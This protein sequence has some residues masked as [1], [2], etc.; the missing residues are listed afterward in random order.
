MIRYLKFLALPAACLFASCAGNSDSASLVPVGVKASSRTGQAV[1][2]QVAGG[3]ADSV[4]LANVSDENFK[5]ALET[6]LVESGLFRSKG[7]GGYQL[8]ALITSVQQPLAGLSMTV[9]MEVSY[10]LRKNGSL[11]WSQNIRSSYTAPIGEAFSGAVR[12]RKAT[13]GA[14]RENIRLLIEALDRKL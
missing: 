2:A 3:T 8:G 11:L 5:Q 12:V 1:T 9:S 6:S 13:E 7:G 4:L 14:S 10:T